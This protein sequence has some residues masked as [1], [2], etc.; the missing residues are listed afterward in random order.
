MMP[1]F[2][3]PRTKRKRARHTLAPTDT[4]TW[5]SATWYTD[6]LTLED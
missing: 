6:R 2:L 4:R 3:P 1:L 5:R